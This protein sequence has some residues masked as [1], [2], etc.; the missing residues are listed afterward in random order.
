[1]FVQDKDNERVG[2]GSST[3]GV[4]GCLQ[5]SAG[6]CCGVEGCCLGGAETR[7]EGECYYPRNRLGGPQRA[8][9]TGKVTTGDEVL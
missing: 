6:G 2:E 7:D 1:M 3:V 4:L 5:C 9:V 8:M